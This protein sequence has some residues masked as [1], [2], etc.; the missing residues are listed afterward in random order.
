M[1]E[2]LKN[3]DI[4]GKY[5]YLNLEKKDKFKS[6]IGGIMA[7]ILFL[8]SIGVIF[9]FGQDIYYKTNPLVSN[10]VR[11]LDYFPFATLNNSNFLF[12]MNLHNG[13]S[14]DTIF[15][16]KSFIEFRVT[17]HGV[18][19]NPE[20][21]QKES[22]NNMYP[23]SDCNSSHASEA[24]ILNNN[25]NSFQCAIVDFEIGG[26][27]HLDTYKYLKYE[28]KRCDEATED[29]Y[30]ITCAPANEIDDLLFFSQIGVITQRLIPNNGNFEIP[31][32]P[33][34]NYD[35]YV[36]SGFYADGKYVQNSIYYNPST[37]QSD[38]GFI[39]SDITRNQSFIEFRRSEKEERTPS[40]DY[41]IFKSN[42]YLSNY[43][44]TSIRTY[45]KVP[46]IAARV[47]GLF[48][49]ILE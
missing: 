13:S 9:Y 26:M 36:L 2:F 7:I 20:T 32:V 29:L 10:S 12:A 19:I 33:S 37:V 24:D 34:Y 39:F 16:N 18:S 1:T 42:I 40:K 45:I 41:F 47:G 6:I 43:E 5:F 21:G 28:L 4:F 38:T 23:M 11:Q 35:Y 31:V 14:F 8:G 22:F 17:Y 15:T 30:N 44:T 3:L 27:S 49:C 48:S 46:E 25:L